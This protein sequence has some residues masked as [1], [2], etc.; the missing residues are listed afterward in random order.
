MSFFS[1]R[2]GAIKRNGLDLPNKINIVR[3]YMWKSSHCSRNARLINVPRGILIE[4]PSLDRTL[5]ISFDSAQHASA[6]RESLRCCSHVH[7]IGTRRDSLQQ[8]YYMCAIQHLMVSHDSL[9]G[10]CACARHPPVAVGI[11]AAVGRDRML[12][13]VCFIPPAQRVHYS[14]R[15]LQFND[16]IC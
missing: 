12:A 5:V 9:C 14:N 3:N 4:H 16:V 15:H 2:S 11:G 13:F 1:D 10:P 6:K 7:P 8:V